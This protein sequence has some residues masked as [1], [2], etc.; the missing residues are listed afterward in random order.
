MGLA[1]SQARF[2]LLTSRKDDIDGQLMRIANQKLSLSRESATLSREYNDA[3]KATTLAWATADGNVD[4]SYDMMMRPN[5]A[6]ATG[7]YIVTNASTGSV[8][9]DQS[10][11]DD[12]SKKINYNGIDLSITM[13]PSGRPGDL[14]AIMNK[15][16]FL[17]KLIG[18]DQKTANSYVYGISAPLSSNFTINY[19]DAAIATAAGFL[20]GDSYYTNC[21][22]EGLKLG[23]VSKQG[24]MSSV[25][26]AFDALLGGIRDGLGGQ[27]GPALLDKLGD[28]YAGVITKALDY[29]QQ[30]TYNKFVYNINDADSKNTETYNNNGIINNTDGKNSNQIYYGGSWNWQ[31][32]PNNPDGP[33]IQVFTPNRDVYVNTRQVIDTFFNYFDMYFQQHF[34]GTYG[35]TID[36]KK[37]GD[38]T[39]YRKGSGGTGDETTDFKNTAAIDETAD[40]NGNYLADAYEAR[41]YLNLYDALNSSGWQTNDDVHNPNFIDKEM[42][43]GNLAIKQ[44]KNDDWV[45][46]EVDGYQS[47]LVSE[48]NK[49]AATVAEAEYNTQKTLLD[50]KEA[51]LDLKMSGLETE[52]SAITTE[53]ESV[54]GLIKKRIESSFKIFEA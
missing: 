5:G 13:P 39:T 21:G 11:I 10:Y 2:L 37:V 52:R 49:N 25:I 9:L 33:E 47:A 43:Y 51:K 40:A 1:A 38:S 26:L 14:A 54:Q 44:F 8:I 7:Q 29:A 30:A 4:L 16:Q 34:N 18:C 19:D 35:N 53:I 50:T 27:L 20:G 15:Q 17:M 48:N 23:S 28:R 42:L 32:D 31:E 46:T 3:L 12:L 36:T 22:N 6:G 24:D 45:T 41:Y